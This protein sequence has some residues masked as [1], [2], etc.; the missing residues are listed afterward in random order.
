MLSKVEVM[1][2]SRGCTR[3]WSFCIMKQMYGQ[4]FRTYPIERVLADTDDIY[5]NRRTGGA[6]RPGGIN[7]FAIELAWFVKSPLAPLC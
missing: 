1:E 5:Y 3:T 6:L 4:T 7:R 2:T